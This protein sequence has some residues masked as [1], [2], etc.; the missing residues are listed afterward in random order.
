MLKQLVLII[1]IIIIGC[2]N[3]NNEY[4]TTNNSDKLLS[5]N[6]RDSIAEITEDNPS[7]VISFIDNGIS[8]YYST[9]YDSILRANKLSNMKQYRKNKF[10]AVDCCSEIK[11]DTVK[12]WKI[13]ESQTDCGDNGLYFDRW[14]WRGDSIV[15]AQEIRKYFYKEKDTV[16]YLFDKLYYLDSIPKVF[17]RRFTY[18]EFNSGTTRKIYLEKDIDYI[19]I[20]SLSKNYIEE[21]FAGKN[22]EES[23]I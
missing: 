1:I 12:G 3:S 10:C 16:F 19:T 9:L 4:Q 8:P 18:D 15:F 17:Q 23:D 11:G 22:I 13:I 14:I 21:L 20:D 7:N 6:T 2:K 5:T